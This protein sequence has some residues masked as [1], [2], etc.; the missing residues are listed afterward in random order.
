MNLVRLDIQSIIVGQGTMSSMVTLRP[1]Q[2]STSQLLPI[3]IGGMEGAAISVGLNKRA[4]KRPY[5]HD[6][7]MN[8][9]EALG[10][11]LKDVVIAKVEGTTFFARVM[12]TRENGEVLSLDA[13]PSD[14]LALAVRAKVPI[15]ATEEVLDT[16]AL[17]DFGSV[18]KKAAAQ[19]DAAAFH[20]FIEGLSPE[21]FASGDDT[22]QE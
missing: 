19:D 21:D 14:A 12:L 10:A 11:T 3:R 4:G 16:A 2:G 13:R 20:A 6:L 7:F 18:E 5:T 17:P 9:I 22:T 15:Y 8:T 1:R